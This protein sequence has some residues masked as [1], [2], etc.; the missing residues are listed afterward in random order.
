[1][2]AVHAATLSSFSTTITTS[3]SNKGS[4]SSSSSSK[5]KKAGVVS[6][7]GLSVE[8]N[9]ALGTFGVQVIDWWMCTLTGFARHTG[10]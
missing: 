7:R 8:G 5:K 3:S 10:E 1:L 9:P 4:S 6:L 2:E